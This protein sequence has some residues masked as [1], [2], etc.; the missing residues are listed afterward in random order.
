M[1]ENVSPALAIEAVELLRKFDAW[2]GTFSLASD[3]SQVR[4][5][6]AKLPAPV[7]PDEAEVEALM[8]MDETTRNIVR[9][10]IKRGRTLA[11]QGE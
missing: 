11:A 2:D 5:F 10:A 6:V 9:A 8:S 3:L 4:A 1:T 7:D